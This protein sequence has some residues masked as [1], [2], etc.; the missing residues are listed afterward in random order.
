MNMS[1]ALDGRW[2]V[3]VQS[4]WL[5]NC[6]TPVKQWLLETDRG[7]HETMSFVVLK[8]RRWQRRRMSFHRNVHAR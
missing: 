5:T 3:W 4:E 6:S 7:V 1:S 8:E 2:S